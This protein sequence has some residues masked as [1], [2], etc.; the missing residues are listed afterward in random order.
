MA[1]NEAVKVA[2]VVRV[3][4]KAQVVDAFAE[5]KLRELGFWCSQALATRDEVTE[6]PGLDR[7]TLQ[8][9]LVK[10]SKAK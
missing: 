9:N 1:N 2:L 3:A 4:R 5:A 10:F 8:R 6:E 7:P